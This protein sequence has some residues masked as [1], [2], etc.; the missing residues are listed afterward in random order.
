M[1]VVTSF[2]KSGYD[3]YGKK[4]LET[5]VK[6]WPCK[7]VVYYE[8]L[9]DFVHNKVEYKNLLGLKDLVAF[10]TIIQDRPVCKGDLEE[11]YNYNFDIWKFCRKSFAQFDALKEHKG[12]V[13]WLDADVET[14]KPI[15]QEW[16]DE[17]YGSTGLV[18]LGR[19][20]FYTETGFLGFDTER[21]GF[22]DFLGKYIDC[23]RR[24][25]IFTLPGWHDCYAIDWAIKESGV[26]INNLTPD[27]KKG[28][29]DLNV[30]KKSVLQPYLIHHKGH[31]KYGQAKNF[32]PD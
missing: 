4:F 21:E 5:F 26:K 19:N 18:F 13:I 3:I 23:Y 24:G 14:L 8:S 28:K 32:K 27:W 30:W 25:K 31:R 6:H 12:K 20:G 10:L 16:I 2:S 11:G 15:T 9:P 22:Q 17:L 1:I 29:D 7:V